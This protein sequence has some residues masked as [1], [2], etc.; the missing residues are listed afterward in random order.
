MLRPMVYGLAAGL[1]ATSG[2]SHA[3]KPEPKLQ[4]VYTADTDLCSSVDHAL[5][6]IHRRFPHANYIADEPK[7]FFSSPGFAEP[8]WLPKSD[9]AVVDLGAGDSRFLRLSFGDGQRLIAVRNIALGS[10]G[11][12]TTDVLIAKPGKNLAVKDDVNVNG[13]PITSADP[14]DV[15]LLINFEEDDTRSPSPYRLASLSK[16][17]LSFDK[18]SLATSNAMKSA[19][20]LFIA[21][22]SQE[23]FEFKGKLYFLVGSAFTGPWTIYGLGTNAAPTMECITAVQ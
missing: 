22:D 14:A 16:R 19:N 8:H 2:L 6:S 21:P 1:M 18:R 10:H 23:A 4:R 7:A 5:R 11:D 12:F 20:D 9:P 17:T 13:H 3:Q 15:E